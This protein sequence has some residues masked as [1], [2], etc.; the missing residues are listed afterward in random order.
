ME[1][2]IDQSVATAHYAGFWIRVAAY[3]IDLIIAGAIASILTRL[4]FGNYFYAYYEPGSD[5]ASSAVS[6]IVNWIYFAY[7][8]SSVKQ[9]TIGK[10][11]V[12]IKV[13]S[14]SGAR[15]TFANATGRFFAK[16]LS[17]IILFIG[18]IMVAFDNK[19][20]GLHDK[21]AKTVVVYTREAE[22]H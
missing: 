17:A 13:Y 4:F 2:T 21:L 19:K 5:P 6:L 14:E 8:E 12:G 16:I 7:Q 15:L 1:K 10:L 3:L 20:Q 11:A 22:V 18:F 9:A